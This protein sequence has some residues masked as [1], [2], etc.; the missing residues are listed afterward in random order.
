MAISERRVTGTVP[1]SGTVE[2]LFRPDNRLAATVQQVGIEAPNVGGGA[3]GNIYKNSNLIT[4]FVATGDAPAGE[5]FIR[6]GT[7][8]V[9]RV[10]WT[11]ATP[12][13]TVAAT[14]IYDDGAPS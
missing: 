12:G 14:F 3:V 9:M 10:R 5:P 1:A 6:I 11:S 7:S 13:A 4:P 8:D 2:L